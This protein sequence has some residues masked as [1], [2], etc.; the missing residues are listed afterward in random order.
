MERQ[1]VILLRFTRQTG[2]PHPNLKT[3]V[4]NYGSLLM[5]MGESEEQ[6]NARLKGLD[7]EMFDL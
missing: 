7:P 5:K 2:H 3:A 4:N 6:I 1:L